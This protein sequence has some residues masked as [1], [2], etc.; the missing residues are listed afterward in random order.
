MNAP[1]P[2]NYKQ[3]YQDRLERTRVAMLSKRI[4]GRQIRQE[5]LSVKFLADNGYTHNPVTDTMEL[6]DGR[7]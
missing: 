7:N 3:W 4:T 5:N 2:Q 6:A 1:T